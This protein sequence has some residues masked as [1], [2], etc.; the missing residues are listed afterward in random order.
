MKGDLTK[1]AATQKLRDKAASAKTEAT[2]SQP[3]RKKP[4]TIKKVH[5]ICLAFMQFEVLVQIKLAG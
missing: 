4:K 5:I 3:P 1:K 2:V